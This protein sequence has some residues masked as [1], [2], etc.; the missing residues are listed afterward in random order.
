MAEAHVSFVAL[1]SV[2]KTVTYAEIVAATKDDTVLQAC[3]SA[4]IDNNWSDLF[5]HADPISQAELIRAYTTFR[6]ELTVTKDRDLLIRDHR[7][8]IPKSLRKRILNIAHEGHQG[9]TKTKALLKEKVWFPSIDRLTEAIV[10]DCL[11]CQSNTIEHNK[12]PLK[13]SPLPSR[14][15]SEIS[16]DF[17]DIPNGEH[18]LVV[19]DDYSRFPDVEI[20]SSTSAQQS[21]PQTRSHFLHIRCPKRCPYRQWAAL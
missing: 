17:A 15:W 14:P 3:M 2:P 4:I 19:I 21:D 20:V 13:M 18:L 16:V 11:A 12:E 1:H 10:R 8:V 7:L 5:A 6:D 9:I